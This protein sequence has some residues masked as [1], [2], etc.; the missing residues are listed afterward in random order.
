MKNTFT[1]N[2]LLTATLLLFCSTQQV[3]AYDPDPVIAS[4]IKESNR[5]RKPHL[6]Y[7]NTTYAGPL[8][9]QWKG[10]FELG[11]QYHLNPYFAVA[12]AIGLNSRTK[13]GPQF[14]YHLDLGVRAYTNPDDLAGFL[15]LGG[16]ISSNGRGHLRVRPGIEY[17]VAS[18][19]TLGVFGDFQVA[20]ADNIGVGAFAGLAF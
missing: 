2:T 6:I 4:E 15:D 17:R 16:G 20:V 19:F 9:P 1:K 10:S 3:K 14:E 18:G 12:T 13:Q 7:G 8:D 5:T 11:Y